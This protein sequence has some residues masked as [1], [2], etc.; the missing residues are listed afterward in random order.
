MKSNILTF[1]KDVLDF[2]H[3]NGRHGLPWRSSINPYNIL[4][5]EVMLQQTQVERVV[6]KYEAFLKE[7][8]TVQALSTAP[9]TTVQKLWSGLGYNRRA[10]MLHEAAKYIVSEC[11]GCFPQ[12]IESLEKLPGVGPYTARAIITFAYNKRVAMI[13]TNIR[14]VYIHHFF[15]DTPEV[16]DVELMEYIEKSLAQQDPREWYAALM[17]YGTYL[18]KTKVNPSR[19]SSQ[20]SKQSKFKG[21]LREVRG[22]VLPLLFTGG[23]TL[24][25]LLRNSDFSEERIREALAG[26][27]T[28]KLVRKSKNKWELC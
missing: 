9:L 28:D 8:P 1:Q 2:Y 15:K 7:F 5:S 4:V 23:Q 18:K 26:L 16:T 27:I 14:S 12:D 25:Y 24:K 10:R 17:D 13:E 21:S 19:Q 6:P 11:D 3:T 20:Y 22:K